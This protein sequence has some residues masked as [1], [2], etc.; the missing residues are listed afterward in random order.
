MPGAGAEF[1]PL[2]STES[3]HMQC[4]STR[5]QLHGCPGAGASARAAYL[6]QAATLLSF[7]VS[8]YVIMMRYPTPIA[9]SD[10]LRRD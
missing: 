9:V 5:A 1:V 10:S 7:V 4:L 8:S 2:A 3:N 6:I